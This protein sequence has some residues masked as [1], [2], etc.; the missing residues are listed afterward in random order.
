[1][2]IDPRVS[3]GHDDTYNAQY[4]HSEATWTS[5]ARFGW[6]RTNIL[7]A[8]ALTAVDSERGVFVTKR[9]IVRGI[10]TFDV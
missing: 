1:V 5:V 4:T 3:A 8:T 7:R 6:N 2:A 10:F 9:Q